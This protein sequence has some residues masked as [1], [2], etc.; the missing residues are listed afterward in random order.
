MSLGIQRSQAR[1]DRARDVLA[2]QQCLADRL[3]SQDPLLHRIAMELVFLCEDT[4]FVLTVTHA[5]IAGLEA[6]R[7]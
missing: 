4:L 6:Q 7:A 3:C 5:M 1:I 2:I